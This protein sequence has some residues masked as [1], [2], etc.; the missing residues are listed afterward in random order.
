MHRSHHLIFHCFYCHELFMFYLVVNA[1][2]PT[3]TKLIQVQQNDE[4]DTKEYEETTI[5]FSE[6]L[7]QFDSC[8]D[9]LGDE[10]NFKNVKF[11]QDGINR[12]CGTAGVIAKLALENQCQK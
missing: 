9:T 2:A 5:G 10:A 4:E 7:G 6:A 3:T 12:F 8:I 11:V 1:M